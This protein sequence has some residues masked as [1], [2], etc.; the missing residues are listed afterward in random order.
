MVLCCDLPAI[1]LTAA[2]S[3]INH[4]MKPHWSAVPSIAVVPRRSRV[5]AAKGQEQASRNPVRSPS[6]YMENLSDF[7]VSFLLRRG[8]HSR[9]L[10]IP[11]S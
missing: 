2:V 4:R 11:P 7:P 5:T 10:D 1:A 9:G 6:P 3:A 8:G